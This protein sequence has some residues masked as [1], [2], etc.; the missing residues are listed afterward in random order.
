MFLGDFG[1]YWE[2]SWGL[3]TDRHTGMHD[4]TVIGLVG[5]GG[6]GKD[7]VAGYLERCYDVVSLRFSDPI[8]ELLRLFFDQPSREDQSWVGS[9]FRERFGKD[10]FIRAVDRRIRA[11]GRGIFSING[12]RY[13]EDASFVRSFAKHAMIYVTAD[14]RLRWERSQ[15]RGE[16]SDDT[17][18][19]ETFRRL[20]ST[21]ET[22]KGI[23]EIGKRADY[24][25]RNE[26]TPDELF[27]SVD[28]IMKKISL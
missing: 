16:K 18:D 27:I 24:S 21:L 22:E 10:I 17:M 7:T 19:F 11:A 23:G 8:K 2:C 26:G 6:S 14:Q 9:T 25:I 3:E 13:E 28:R 4:V 5:E 12:I 20:E 1:V 15:R